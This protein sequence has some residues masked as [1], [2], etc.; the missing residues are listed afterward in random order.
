MNKTFAYLIT[1]DLLDMAKYLDSAGL[2]T[3]MQNVFIKMVQ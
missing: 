3:F 2:G 1:H